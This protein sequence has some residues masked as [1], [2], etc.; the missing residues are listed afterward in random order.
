MPFA[1]AL[2]VILALLAVFQIALAAGAPWG[3]FAWGG[4]HRVLPRNLRIGS[5]VSIV[6]Y[7][8]IAFVAWERVGASS[9]LPDVVAQVAM[10]VVFAYFAIGIVMNAISRSKQER[11]TMT[12]IVLVLAVL[13]LLI[14]MGLGELAVAA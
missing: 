3:H 11:Y 13:S 1:L 6:I 9:V 2:T 8:V 7:A 14:A 12:P 5:V 10:W 4:Q